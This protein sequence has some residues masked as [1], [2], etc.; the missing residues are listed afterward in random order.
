M[1][2]VVIVLLILAGV[3]FVGGLLAAVL[4]AISDGFRH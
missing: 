4:D 1:E 2:T 3:A